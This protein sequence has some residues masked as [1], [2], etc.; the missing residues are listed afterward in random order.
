MLVVNRDSDPV[1]LDSIL[2]KVHA[3]TRLEAIDGLRVRVILQRS[4]MFRFGG[5]WNYTNIGPSNFSCCAA[6]F[7][8][9]SDPRSA[10]FADFVSGEYSSLEG[11]NIAGSFAPSPGLWLVLKGEGKLANF[12]SF[13]TLF[14]KG[15]L[16]KV[17]HNVHASMSMSTEAFGLSL[18]H[19]PD[20]HLS[21]GVRTEVLVLLHTSIQSRPT[22]NKSGPLLALA[23]TMTSTTSAASTRVSSHTL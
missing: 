15:E 22:R 3:M 11:Y 4:P 9:D 6:M 7:N 1:E 12:T 18:L 20:R 23:T 5:T 8:T 14:L 21:Y 19:R 2:S 10:Q 16:R 13:S 17:I